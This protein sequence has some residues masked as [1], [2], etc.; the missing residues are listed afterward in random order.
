MSNPNSPILEDDQKPVPFESLLRLLDPERERAGEKYEQLRRKLIK[1]FEWNSCFPPED[2]A[3]ETFKRLEHKIDKV[4]IVDVGGF[5]WGIAKNVR[6]ETRKQ[7]G[8]T[9]H[10]PDLERREGSWPDPYDSEEAIGE[11]IQQERRLK[12]LQLC[13]QRMAKSDRELFLAY[14]NV[15]GESLPYRREMAQ[16]LGLTLGALRVRVNRL[17]AQLEKCA[18]QC[19]AW[20]PRHSRKAT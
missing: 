20:R 8:R 11:K 10:I 6:Q 2:L 12:C 14:H 1:F 19:F 13:L 15:S 7:A 16:R 17:R 5:T 18:R 3:D 4:Q 9:L